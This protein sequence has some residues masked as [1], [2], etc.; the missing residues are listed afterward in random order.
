MVG[1]R[2]AGPGGQGVTICTPLELNSSLERRS[3]ARA[4][5]SAT[6]TTLWDWSKGTGQDDAC[7]SARIDRRASRSHC[8]PRTLTSQQTRRNSRRGRAPRPHRARRR[9]AAWPAC[10]HRSDQRPVSISDG[11]SSDRL[12]DGPPANTLD[13][14]GH[15]SSPVRV[16]LGPPGPSAAACFRAFFLACLRSRRSRT[17]FSRFSFFIVVFFLELDAMRVRPFVWIPSASMTRKP[18]VPPGQPVS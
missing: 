5:E 16:S 4:V 11:P 2:L 6:L 10:G 14:V 1:S 8:L 9:S 18:V 7:G 13:G 15:R 17:A 12:H 3:A